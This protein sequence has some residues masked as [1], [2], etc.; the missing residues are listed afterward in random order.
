M[1]EDAEM[2][3]QQLGMKNMSIVQ[4]NKSS[5]EKVKHTSMAEWY[6]SLGDKLLKEF[7]QLYYNDFEMLGYDMA[8]ESDAQ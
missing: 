4:E 1:T 6:G 7:H 8:L 3:L 5:G 2:A